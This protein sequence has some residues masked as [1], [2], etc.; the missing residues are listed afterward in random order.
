VAVP[1]VKTTNPDVISTGRMSPMLDHSP[2]RR[3]SDNNIRGVGST[4]TNSKY[5]QSGLE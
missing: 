3:D 2:W 4:D 5:K 1:T